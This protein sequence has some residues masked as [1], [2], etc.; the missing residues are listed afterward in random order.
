MA[1]G[2]KSFFI[3]I[4]FNVKLEHF[5][6]VGSTLV[7]RFSTPGRPVLELNNKNQN[8][9][10]LITQ[11]HNFLFENKRVAWFFSLRV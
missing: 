11:R 10:N 8:S 4:F 5:L 7:F 2:T 1:F 6:N 9:F 3:S